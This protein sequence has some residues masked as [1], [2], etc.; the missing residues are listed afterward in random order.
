MGNIT[1][2][3]Y[4][5][6]ADGKYLLIS[7]PKFKQDPIS[8]KEMTSYLRLGASSLL[9]RHSL[10]SP[11]SDPKLTYDSKHSHESDKR[12]TSPYATSES[13]PPCVTFH[14]AAE[15]LLESTQSTAVPVLPHQI[16]GKSWT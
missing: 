15:G 14:R 2:G 12:A 10:R 9:N 16:L 11:T 1:D 5:L 4:D 13:A 8:G 7:V 3:S 6:D